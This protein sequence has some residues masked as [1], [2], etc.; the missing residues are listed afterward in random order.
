MTLSKQLIPNKL[1]RNKTETT[2]TKTN[3]SHTLEHRAARA[4]IYYIYMDIL[5][6]F[7]LVSATNQLTYHMTSD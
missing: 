2:A 7:A 5:H 3:N 6:N 1:I 4:T